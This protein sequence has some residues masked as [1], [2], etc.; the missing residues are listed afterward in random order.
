MIRRKLQELIAG[1]LSDDKVIILLGSR[2]VGKTT[3]LKEIIRNEDAVVKWNGDDPDIREMLRNSSSTLLKTL[4]GNAKFVFIDEAQRIENIGLCIKQ[5]KDN[6]PGC[7]VFATGSSAF[8]LAN[9]INEPLTGR[10]WEYRLYPL[11]FEEM[12][13]HQGLLE[14]QRMLEHR[15]IYGYYPEVI[16]NPGNEEEILTQLA[17][18]FLYKDILT[19]ERIQKPDRLERLVQAIAFQTGN[20]VSYNELGQISGLDNQTVEH[21]INLLE[22]AFIVYRL[23]T[24]NR[25][26]RDELK[27]SRKIYFYDNGLRNAVIKQFSP[28][29]LRNDTGALWENFIL[30]ERLK[31]LEYNRLHCNRFF[32][33]NQAQQEIDYIEE[34]NGKIEAY[35][36]KWSD[37]KTIKKFPAKFTDAYQPAL[38]KVIT[39]DNF[40]EFTLP[41]K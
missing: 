30:A 11:S 3:L 37:K 33:R 17:D 40:R 12:V 35:E 39:R 23:G 32:W 36:F 29:A 6:L 9:K 41:A 16:N 14:E 7:K 21:Y 26:L 5:I 27:K 25:N 4:I 31:T 18:S 22:K 8:E 19:W 28:L 15:M 10:K 24:F 34:R 1:R 13:D 20:L 2:Q 38:T